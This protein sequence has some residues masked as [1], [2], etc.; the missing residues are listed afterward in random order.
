MAITTFLAPR[1]GA[2]PSRGEF[3][4]AP[5]SFFWWPLDGQRHAANIQDR[6]LPNGEPIS[7]LCDQDL[8]RAPAGDTEWL[9]PTCQGCWDAT[10]ARVGLR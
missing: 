8:T 7:T 3:F 4:L 6:E 5:R 9:W 2:E 10:A 1:D